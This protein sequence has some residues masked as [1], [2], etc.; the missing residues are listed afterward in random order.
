MIY[1]LSSS[2][3]FRLTCFVLMALILNSCYSYFIIKEKSNDDVAKVKLKDGSEIILKDSLNIIEKIDS[4][5]IMYKKPDGNLYSINTG[6]IAELY[7][8]KFD[9][10]KTSFMVLFSAIG[11]R[12]L[13]EVILHFKYSER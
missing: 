11:I 2:K 8:Y 10:K 1:E 12:L 9:I 5:S 7:E 4:S 3:I 13:L 6:D